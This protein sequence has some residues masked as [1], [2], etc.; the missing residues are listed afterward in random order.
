MILFKNRL[1]TYN[2]MEN[3]IFDFGWM[4]EQQ[5]GPAMT[6][7]IQNPFNSFGW[8]KKTFLN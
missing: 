6:K 8:K 5:L 1:E 2:K 4:L 7:L 3:K